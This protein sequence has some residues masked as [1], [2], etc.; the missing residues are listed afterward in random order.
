MKIVVQFFVSYIREQT[1]NK[2]DDL[3]CEICRR[4][5]RN[6]D[7]MQIFRS[8]SAQFFYECE[9][10]DNWVK[11]PVVKSEIY[12]TFFSRNTSVRSANNTSPTR[13]DNHGWRKTGN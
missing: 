9:K 10:I 6:R 13:S 4:E 1:I 5:E 11:E 2:N 7:E 3:I 12:S 8:C